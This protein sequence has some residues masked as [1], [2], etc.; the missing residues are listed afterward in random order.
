MAKDASVNTS[1]GNQLRKEPALVKKRL[2]ST[3]E[4]AEFLG[5]SP[6]TLYNNSSRKVGSASR[7]P[8]PKRI[9]RKLL[10]DI[11]VLNRFVDGLS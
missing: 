5:L 1:Y 7:I 8:P 10:W 9:G 2:L 3:A 4:A 11:E 6:R